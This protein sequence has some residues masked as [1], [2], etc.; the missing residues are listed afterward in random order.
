MSKKRWLYKTQK[1]NIE[2][3]IIVLRFRQANENVFMVIFDKIRK[4]YFYIQKTFLT[5]L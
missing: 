3:E 1:S 4:G 2:I 5:E